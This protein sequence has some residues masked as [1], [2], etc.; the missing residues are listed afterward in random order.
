[1]NKEWCKLVEKRV[2]IA[3][4]RADE[5]IKKYVDPIARV[6]NPEK[7]LGK[8]YDAWTEEDIQKLKM[9]Y[10]YSPEDLE[11]FINKKEIDKIWQMMEATKRMEDLLNG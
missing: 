4:K 6:D 5:Y 3:R 7:L 10:V 1:M 9:V 8:P 11:T 2:D